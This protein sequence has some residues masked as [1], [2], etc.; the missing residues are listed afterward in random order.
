MKKLS[1]KKMQ[2]LLMMV[3][4]SLAVPVFASEPKLVSGTVALAKAASGWL[5]GAILAT[6][7]LFA[8]YFAWQKSISQDD[9]NIAKYNKLIK[10]TV[11]G[12]V[13][14]MTISGLITVILSFYS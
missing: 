4:V 12:A 9:A 6:A 13:I 1:K 3:M 11:V 2:L 8:G 5:T 10:N 7:G 14:A